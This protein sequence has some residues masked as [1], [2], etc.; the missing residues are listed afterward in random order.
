[1]SECTHDCSTCGEACASRNAPQDMHEALNEYSRV[2]KVIA[3]VS[4]KG[5]VG[6]SLVTS[7]LAV[8][9]QRRG[10]KTAILDA[11]I[12]GPSIPEA[13]GLHDKAKGSAAGI[14]PEVTK[15]GIDVMSVNLLLEDET[16]PV[17]WR[18]P[19]IA[20]TVKQFWTDVVWSDVD[21]MFV[22][23][24]P[25]T[26]DVPLTVFQSL[27][28]D[29]IVIVTSPQELVSMIVGKAVKMARLMNIPV[30]ALVENMSY[31]SC[32][33]CG[34]RIAVFGESKIDETAKQFGVDIACR[35]PIEPKLTAAMDKG[36]IELFEGDWLK[37][38]EEKLESDAK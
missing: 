9:M 4:G 27:P 23:M 5:G 11:D 20:G 8:G 16:D 25:G 37:A 7:L 13:F 29:G 2:G 26:G 3:V 17:V 10:F 24:P 12:T 31:V 22:D 6:K 14:L 18:G 30:L 33:D 32:P 38:I 28:V 36:M 34:R 1:M 21:Y 19:I 15:T 35:I